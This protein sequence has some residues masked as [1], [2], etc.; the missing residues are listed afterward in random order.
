MAERWRGHLEEG[1]LEL[2]A[3]RAPGG[4]PLHLFPLFSWPA[5]HIQHD[6]PPPRVKLAWQQWF[7]FVLLG[8]AGCGVLG[9][10]RCRLVSSNPGSTIY[11]SRSSKL[12]DFHG[13]VFPTHETWLI[14]TAVRISAYKEL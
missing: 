3:E 8:P 13:S 7:G 1:V 9:G 12:P 5:D 4:S 2:S 6:F 11:S 14:V 10:C